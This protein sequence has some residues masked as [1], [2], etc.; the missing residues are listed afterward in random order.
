MH[1]F[2]RTALLAVAASALL[3]SACGDDDPT[4]IDTAGIESEIVREL[5]EQGHLDV[6]A[7]C[8][9]EQAI[10]EGGTFECDVLLEGETVTAEVVQEDDQGNFS[11]ELDGEVEPQTP[12]EEG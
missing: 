2:R 12:P 3:G 11:W 4:Q 7:T 8:P 1:A 9:D 5:T 6:E 10:E